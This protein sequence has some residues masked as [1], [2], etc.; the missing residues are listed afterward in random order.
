MAEG[1]SAAASSFVLRRAALPGRSA[2]AFRLGDD[3]AAPALQSGSRPPNVRAGQR[4]DA[5]PRARAA[6]G[7]PGLRRKRGA[8]RRAVPDLA[9]FEVSFST[10]GFLYRAGMD[11]DAAYPKGTRCLMEQ[12]SMQESAS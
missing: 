1:P 7:R 10:T 12:R 2:S 5:M 11:P 6:A 3:P 8:A 4:R 9:P